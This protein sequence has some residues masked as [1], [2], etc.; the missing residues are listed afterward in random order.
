MSEPYRSHSSSF[1]RRG[2]I[3]WLTGLPGSGKSTIAEELGRQLSDADRVICILD[4]DDL[5]QGLSCDL[6]FAPSDRH[7]HLRRAG[8]LA[9]LLADQDKLV[10]AAIIS[11]Y[12]A[13]RRVVRSYAGGIPF[14]EV[15]VDADIRVCIARDPKG[16]YRKALAGEIGGLTGID[17]PYEIPVDPELRLDTEILTVAE[18]VQAIWLAMR[19]R[20]LLP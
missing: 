11:P 8:K 14:I 7:Q 16:L 15:H 12:A 2:G 18:S 3:V 13:D 9:R 17:A 20:G 6:G 10:I 1:Q 4:G 19:S 5:R